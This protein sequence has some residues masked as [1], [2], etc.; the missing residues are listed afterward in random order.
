[1]CGIIMAAA[2][3]IGWG[4]PNLYER[5]QRAY[6]ERNHSAYFSGT[7]AK[8]VVYGTQ[9]CA[10]CAKGRAYLQ[11][12]HFALTHSQLAMTPTYLCM[13]PCA[14]GWRAQGFISHPT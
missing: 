8:V 13:W 2:L 3:A 5:L 11:D 1:M 12:F 7:A 10:Y 6:G 9:T 4:V 14:G